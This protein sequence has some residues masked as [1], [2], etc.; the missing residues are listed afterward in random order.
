[1]PLPPTTKTA[2]TR[3]FQRDV[4]CLFGLPVDNLAMASTKA[5]LRE[6]V[7]QEGTTVLSTINVNWVTRSF[8]DAE[9]RSAILNSDLVVL[10][11]KPLLWLAKLLGCPIRETVPGSSLIDELMAEKTD[12]PMTI[13]LFGG[14]DNTAKLAMERINQRKSGLRAV[15]ALNP[16]FGNVEDMSSDAI[17]DAINKTKPDIFLVALGAKKGTQWIERN[18][19]RLNAKIISH[20]GA[21]INF[22]AGTVKRA[23]RFMQAS[24][25]EWVWR[26]MQEPKLF[27]RYA[28]DGFIML[29][30][31][32][33]RLPLWWRYRHLRTQFWQEHPDAD[34]SAQEHPDK[35]LFSFGR[36]IRST[37]NLPLQRAF[38]N[39]AGFEKKI[40]LDFKQTEYV[41]SNF[42][43]MLL[44]L[45]FKFHKLSSNSIEFINIIKIKNT[46]ELFGL[47]PIGRTEEI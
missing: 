31:I 36:N 33:P 30:F 35:I 24:G 1:M 27:S 25:L 23:P 37:D 11:G 43:G 20:L 15:G 32:L 29:R 14:E 5:L 18:R 41:E 16:G 17:I 21:T 13:F 26:I 19:H 3:D 42:L 39:Y 6:R 7:N 46:F 2:I 45:Q 40:I 8:T 4:W 44:I 38:S 10:D 12:K 22:L 28:E 34:A 9:F 47:E